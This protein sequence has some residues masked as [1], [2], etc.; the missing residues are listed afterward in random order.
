MYEYDDQQIKEEALQS[1]AATVIQRRWKE[2]C[3]RREAEAAALT[4]SDRGKLVAVA[5]AAAAA[6][7]TAGDGAAAGGEEA[8]EDPAVYLDEYVR[9]VEKRRNV[10]GRSLA[11]QRQLARYFAAQRQRKGE[12]RPQPVS[13]EAEQQYWVAVRQLQEERRVVQDRKE[14][15]GTLLSEVKARHQS[16]IEEALAQEEQFRQYIRQLAEESVFVRTHQRLTAEEIDAFLKKETEQRHEVRNARIRHILLCH[17]LKKLQKTAEQRDQQ[18]DGMNLI[19]FEQLKIENTNLNE[20]IEERN[21]DLLKLR[22]KVT[23]T[24]HVLTHVKEKL[25]FM[26]IENAQLRRQVSM[27]EDELNELRDKLA[28]TKRRR[29]HFITSNIKMRESMPMVGSE[30]LL[31]DYEKRKAACNTMRQNVLDNAAKHKE[32][33]AATDR[34]QVVL[35]RLQKSLASGIPAN[36]GEKPFNMLAS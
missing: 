6:A 28:Q 34:N 7:A 11:C 18:Q 26:K 24:I 13:P 27:T 16:T 1:K 36:V 10:I 30:K 32:L 19:D 17:E 3:A 31:V 20:K 22:R 33:L 21:E 23:T 14:A 35:N 5:A 8:G 25:E 15:S 2:Y 9:L 12:E 29:D 4:T